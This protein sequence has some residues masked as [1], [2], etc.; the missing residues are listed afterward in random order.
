MLKKNMSGGAVAIDGASRVAI[1]KEPNHPHLV[2]AKL[3]GTTM[4]ATLLSVFS[5][6][7]KVYK[8]VCFSVELVSRTW[9]HGF[10]MVHAPLAFFELIQGF[11][12]DW[13]WK[14][15]FH[16]LSVEGIVVDTESPSMIFLADEQDRCGEWQHVGPYDAL[17][18]H[19]IALLLYLIL[20][21]LQV[22]IR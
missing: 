3:S 1:F 12:N 19:V 20:Q 21:Q 10:I 5:A 17:M 8:I 11:A 9:I 6:I 7:N 2:Q 13:D 16:G 4:A 18:E 22:S 14:L 15:V